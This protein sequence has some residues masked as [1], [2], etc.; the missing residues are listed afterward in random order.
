MFD[1]DRF[2][3]DCRGALAER[4]TEAIREVVRRAAPTPPSW[5]ARL[6]LGPE[7]GQPNR[8]NRFGMA[9]KTQRTN[10]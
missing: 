5:S 2:A 9:A 3:A 4:G 10:P 1:I 6:T 8:K 7:P